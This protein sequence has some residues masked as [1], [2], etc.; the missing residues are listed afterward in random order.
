MSAAGIKTRG[1]EW[2]GVQ[3]KSW[4]FVLALSRPAA[5]VADSCVSQTLRDPSVYHA[6]VW[7]LRQPRSVFIS[8]SISLKRTCE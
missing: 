6:A 8:G 1:L 5:C 2:L 3:P 4:Q 7:L